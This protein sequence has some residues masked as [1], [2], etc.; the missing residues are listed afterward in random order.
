MLGAGLSATA[1]GLVFAARTLPLVGFILVGGVWADRLPRQRLM[2][3]SD[4]VRGTV[5]VT[6]GVLVVADAARL[7]QFLVLIAVYG[8]AEA[9]F[10][11]AATGLMPQVVSR[12]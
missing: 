5:L 1:V 6:L 9:F 12:R 2:L 8:G 11:P 7:W 4:L 10:R 3:A